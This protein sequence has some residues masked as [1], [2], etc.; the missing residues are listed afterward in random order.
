MTFFRVHVGQI[1]PM[2][3]KVYT[4]VQDM[5]N[6]HCSPNWQIFPTSNE[7][8]RNQQSRP[9][10]QLKSFSCSACVRRIQVQIGSGFNWA[11]DPNSDWYIGKQKRPQQKNGKKPM[12]KDLWRAEGFAC[13]MNMLF[14]GLRINLWC[15]VK[16]LSSFHKFLFFKF[17]IKKFL[18][19]IR[20]RMILSQRTWIRNNGLSDFTDAFSEIWGN[21]KKQA[22]TYNIY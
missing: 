14:L 13:R 12:W 16:N 22:K 20:I 7:G 1:W 18:I 21:L 4:V 11:S 8:W 15:S 9:G 19:E 10:Y 5:S 3:L 17:F 2:T 6:I